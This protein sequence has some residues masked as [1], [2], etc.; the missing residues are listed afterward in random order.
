MS[1]IVDIPMYFIFQD[2][3]QRIVAGTPPVRLNKRHTLTKAALKANL[4]IEK[5]PSPLL[6]AMKYRSVLDEPSVDILSEVAMRCGVS[7]ARV[8]QGLSLLNLDENIQKY[9]MNIE[10]PKE[11]NFWTERRLRPIA[12]IEDQEEQK[13]QFRK[14]LAGFCETV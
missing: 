13:H 9:L 4:P 10:D 14:L 5:K 11:H 8:S 3:K 12:M 2:R 1:A 6:L 7:R